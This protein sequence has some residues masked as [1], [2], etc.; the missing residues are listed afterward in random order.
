MPTSTSR[1]SLLHTRLV[2]VGAALKRL[3]RG[4]MS[5][6][7]DLREGLQR[8]RHVLPLIQLDRGLAGKIA[9]RLKKVSRRL[10]PVSQIDAL[11]NATDVVVGD[12]RHLRHA[13]L[14]LKNELRR[15]RTQLSAGALVRRTTQDL[16]KVL[17]RLGG[18]ADEM[19]GTRES[20][21]T[22]RARRWAI[23]ARVA[24]R[25]Q[26]LKKAIADAGAVYLPGR[27]RP[28]RRATRRLRLSAD[29][30]HD[31]APTVRD[32]DVK[33]LEQMNHVLDRLCDGERLVEEVRRIQGTL[34][35]PDLK[36]WQELDDLTLAVEHHCRRLHGRYVREREALGSVADRLGARAA[37]GASRRKAS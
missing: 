3:N 10:A 22:V 9:S 30:L 35:P 31:A 16:N 5:A 27:L 24:R 7:P 12:D 19:L 34:A 33:L 20:A 1:H 13:D 36:A 37:N 21:T 14:R 15:I 29:L 32:P 4:D 26:E 6:V 23:K 17:M 2:R 18:A 28:V 8:L 25:A 11:L